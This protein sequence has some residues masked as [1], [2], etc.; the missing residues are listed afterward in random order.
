MNGARLRGQP[1]LRFAAVVGCVAA[2]AGGGVLVASGD[3]GWRPFAL[4]VAALTLAWVLTHAG[5]RRIELSGGDVALLVALTALA[6]AF[7]AVRIDA[8]PYGLWTDERACAANALALSDRPFT[9]FGAT[10]LFAVGPDWVRTSNLYL[11]ACD[12]VL[13]TFG[14]NH[15]G[16]KMISVLPGVLAVPLLYLL[17]RRFLDRSAAALSAGLLAVS[18]W[19]VTLSR[20]GWDEVLTTALAVA[21]FAC[22]ASPDRPATDRPLLAGG[23]L[24]GLA[25]YAY[26]GA[27]LLVVAAVVFLVLRWLQ[28]RERHA[29][30][31]GA[32][33]AAGLGLAG[34]PLAAYWLRD[35]TAFGARIRDLAGPGD[36]L[37]GNF[38][39]LLGNAAAYAG[40]FFLAG[41]RNPRHNLPGFPML[42]AIAGVLF[43]VGFLVSV[44]RHRRAMSQ[45]TLAWLGTG[46]LAGILSAASDAP[47]AYRTGFVAPACYLLAGVGFQTLLSLPARSGRPLSTRTTVL[48]ATILVATSGT[49]SAVNY[50]VVRPAS[51]ACWSSTEDGAPAELVRRCVDEVTR[52]GGRVL[53]DR[54]I[55]WPGLVFQVDTLFGCERPGAPV[56][57][58]DVSGVS[59]D[60]LTGTVAFML[61]WAWEALPPQL[62]TL[63]ARDFDDP[64]GGVVVIAVSSNRDLLR[65]LHPPR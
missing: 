60:S 38:H 46:L 2:G 64:F 44:A 29:L 20:W 58:V 5:D 18:L 15:L 4:W 35:S 13:G 62:R 39:A 36:V 42:D 26:I 53:L 45:M 50:F 48:L 9:P 17:A 6:G 37:G 32:L 10:P 56:R 47:N 23:V 49:V 31:G 57:W 51:R 12:L 55:R 14:A 61:P 28:A 34:A 11:Y 3:E 19:Q 16:I 30:I 65:A 8:I 33:F 59:P 24:A 63:P 7:R 1:A 40:M 41:D 25:L 21:V 54:G 27:R 52:Q 22:I 43:A